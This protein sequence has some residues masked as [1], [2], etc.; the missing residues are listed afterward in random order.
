MKSCPSDSVHRARKQ[1]YLHGGSAKSSTPLTAHELSLIGCEH[2]LQRRHDLSAAVRAL[3]RQ[4]GRVGR[5]AQ[6]GEG[7]GLAKPPRGQVA[8]L[9][10][11]TKVATTLVS[12][13]LDRL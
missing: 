13:Q 3:Q 8:R 2:D 9:S 12:R 1:K 6:E 4:G 5:A 11:P 10:N 7:S